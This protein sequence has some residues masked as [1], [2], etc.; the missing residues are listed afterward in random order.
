M[1]EE[2]L[3]TMVEQSADLTPAERL[4]VMDIARK[5]KR[6]G[7]TTR[8]QRAAEMA[9]PERMA[10][11]A[12]IV[13]TVRRTK[14]DTAAAIMANIVKRLRE[15]YIE[16]CSADERSALLATLPPLP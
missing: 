9:D 1:T 3:K 14:G 6:T 12:E 10:Q 16:G 15:Q 4:Q 11:E 5:L 7:P 13:E 2:Q 8:E